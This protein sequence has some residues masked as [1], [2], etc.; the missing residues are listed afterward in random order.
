MKQ[1][2]DGRGSLI[3][4]VKKMEKSMGGLTFKKKIPEEILEDI[5]EDVS[6]DQENKQIANK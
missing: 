4:K 5:E 3:G 6:E 1:V 2:K